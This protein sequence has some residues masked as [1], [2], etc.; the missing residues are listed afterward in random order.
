LLWD[1][2]ASL[3]NQKKPGSWRGGWRTGQQRERREPPSI[4]PK[5]GE[6]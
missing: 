6:R 4:A 2:P 1:E 3:Q 5:R